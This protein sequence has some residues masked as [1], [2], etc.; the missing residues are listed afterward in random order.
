MTG[1]FIGFLFLTITVPLSLYDIAQHFAHWN[2]PELQRHIVRV[3]WMVPVYSGVQ[4]AV[5]STWMVPS[6]TCSECVARAAL[7]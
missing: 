4:C 5:C 1:Y 6:S 7:P 3:N 2:D